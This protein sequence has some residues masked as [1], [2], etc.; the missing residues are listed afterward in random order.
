[1]QTKGRLILRVLMN[2]F[3]KGASEVLLQG[4]SDADA[5]AIAQLQVPATT[6]DPVISSVAEKLQHTHYS[7]FIP[8]F[9]KMPE[10]ER[11]YFLAAL[12]SDQA[13]RVA[14]HLK[15]ESPTFQLTSVAKRYLLSVLF[16]R[17][18]VASLVPSEFL[19]PAELQE[20][21]TLSKYQL[22]RLI[23]YLGVRDLAEELR[24]IV[25]KMKLKQIINSL[26]P[27][28]QNYLRACLGSKHRNPASRLGLENWD[29]NKESLSHLLHK[30][31]LV[32]LAQALSGQQPEF[33]DSLCQH[34][35]TG[36]GKI[37]K[38][39]YLEK[40]IPRITAILTSQVKKLISLTKS[41][42]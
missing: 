39:R 34:L 21:L 15:V 37:I 35:D 30:R 24:N 41:K 7:W 4:L 3:H 25:D 42:P 27:R 32:R 14:K 16:S 33:V 9:Q 19:Q 6:I 20:L 23:D 10:G 17:S 18:D 13:A 28:K 26:S 11:S 31:G 1:M 40:E 5:E 12:P 38:K 22:M 8:L 36:R 2:R 29:G